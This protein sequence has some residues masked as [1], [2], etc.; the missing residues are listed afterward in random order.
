MELLTLEYLKKIFL[1]NEQ[2][3]YRKIK[4][5]GN[6]VPSFLMPD[7]SIFPYSRNRKLG[8]KK[9]G[10]KV[11]EISEI[12]KVFEFSTWLFQSLYRTGA[13]KLQHRTAF[14]EHQFWWSTSP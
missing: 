6:I 8:F 2:V 3:A 4:N 12:S 5:L 9:L 13:E 7:F 11:S 10:K 1:K 14:A